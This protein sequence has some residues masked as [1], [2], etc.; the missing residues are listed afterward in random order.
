MLPVVFFTSALLEAKA[1]KLGDRFCRCLH[2]FHRVTT[3]L[4]F[5]LSAHSPETPVKQPFTLKQSQA[6]SASNTAKIHAGTLFICCNPVQW[7]RERCQQTFQQWREKR[8][9]WTISG[10]NHG[11]KDEATIVAVFTDAILYI[12]YTNW[13]YPCCVSLQDEASNVC[14]PCYSPSYHLSVHP[15]IIYHIYF[16]LF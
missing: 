15:L 6:Q 10:Q 4:R 13:K 5:H 12:N 9:Q 16:S 2:G 7:Q 1:K 11:H 3:S 14:P 8:T